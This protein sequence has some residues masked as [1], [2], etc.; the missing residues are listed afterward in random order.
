MHV[1]QTPKLIFK[2]LSEKK[3]LSGCNL[4]KIHGKIYSKNIYSL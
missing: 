1:G 2:Y 4:V 3:N